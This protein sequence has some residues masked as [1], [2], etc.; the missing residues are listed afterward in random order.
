MFRSESSRSRAVFY[1]H[2]KGEEEN[3]GKNNNIT[4]PKKEEEEPLVFYLFFPF[5]VCVE[6]DTYMEMVAKA[7]ALRYGLRYN[8]FLHTMFGC[9]PFIFYFVFPSFLP[10]VFPQKMTTIPHRPHPWKP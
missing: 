7:E 3:I 10:P 8:E 9:C 4:P 6:R 5:F 1:F 2:R